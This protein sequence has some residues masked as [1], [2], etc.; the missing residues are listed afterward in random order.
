MG[1]SLIFGR[2]R[3]EGDI[4][5]P[6]LWLPFAKLPRNTYFRNYII[7]KV[8]LYTEKLSYQFGIVTADN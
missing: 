3:E 1:A 8:Y 5:A 7:E 2:V 4:L 6:N